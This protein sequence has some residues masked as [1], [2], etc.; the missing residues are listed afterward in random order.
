M[1]SS[2]YYASNSESKYYSSLFTGK[3]LRNTPYT[4]GFTLYI[5]NIVLNVPLTISKHTR[6]VSGKTKL[7]P[8]IM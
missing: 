8:F 2:I 7:A 3:P 5:M 6:I 4:K 1:N